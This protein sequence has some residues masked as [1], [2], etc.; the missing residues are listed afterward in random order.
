M[1]KTLTLLAAASLALAAVSCSNPAKIAEAYAEVEVTCVPEVLEVVAGNIDAVVT[2]QFPEKYLNQTGILEVTPVLVYADGEQAMAPFVYQGEKVKENNKVITK[3]GAKISELLH[4]TYV[5]GMEKSTLVFRVKAR[6]GKKEAEGPDRKVAVGCNT[7]YML[8]VNCC[9]GVVAPKAD[10]YEDIVRST[11]EGQVNYAVSSSVVASKQYNTASVKSYQEALKEAIA[12]ERKT[13]AST[14]IVSYA[15]PEGKESFNEKLSANRGTS[16]QKAHAKV[17]KKTQAGEPVE[18]KSVGED[19]EGFQALVAASDLQDKDL[20]IRVLSMYSDPA[21]R[22]AEIKNMSAVYKSLKKE[23][24]PALRRSRFIT[25]VEFQNY[26]AEE[27]KALVESNVDVL[28][29]PALLHAATL[30]CPK[31]QGAQIVALYEKAIEKFASNT[32]KFNLAVYYLQAGDKAAAAKQLAACTCDADVL[33]FQGVLATDKAQARKLFEAA[34]EGGCP[35]AVSNLVSLD[36]AEGKYAEAL[37]VAGKACCCA[38]PAAQK[39]VVYL[40][41]AQPA[42]ALEVLSAK[43][44]CEGGCCGCCAEKEAYVKAIAYARLGQVEKAKEVLAT[45]KSEKLLARAQNDVEFL[46]VL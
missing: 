39:A 40:V 46:T 21:V 14:E 34:V 5:P 26:S 33:N 24:L 28:D 4:F 27:L 30:L 12:N 18:V 29:E 32:A 8:G 31:S 45:I 41:N 43:K 35:A 38:V 23:V 44:C 2:A 20:I 13:I 22:E 17:V 11:I 19:W 3:D 15:S 37:E 10:G 1:K 7:T 9:G 25:N 6:Q 16:G 42:K 36:L